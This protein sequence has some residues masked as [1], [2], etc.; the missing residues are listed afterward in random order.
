MQKG[1]PQPDEE[2]AVQVGVGAG[3]PQISSSFS[4]APMVCQ[5]DALKT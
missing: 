2:T 4:S 5:Y 3:A 1:K